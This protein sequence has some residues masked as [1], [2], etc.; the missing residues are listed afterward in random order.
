MRHGEKSYTYL[1]DQFSTT[2]TKFWVILLDDSQFHTIP[3]LRE[4]LPQGV[5][6]STKDAGERGIRDGDPVRVFNDRGEMVVPARV[7][8]RIRPGV[9]D[10]PQGAWFDPDENGVDRGGCSN[11][12]SKDDSSPGGAFPTNT[13]LVQVA[14]A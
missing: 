5:S 7:T 11:V 8:E 14:R 6:I 2:R 9:V 13:A 3:W 4:I 1:S 12:L 10:V